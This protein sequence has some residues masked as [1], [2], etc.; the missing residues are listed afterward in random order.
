MKIFPKE[1][2]PAPLKGAGRA[3]KRCDV[4]R[5]GDVQGV[6]AHVAKYTSGEH[7]VTDPQMGAAPVAPPPLWGL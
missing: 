7:V 1:G 5:S 3:S 2:A 4:A 6:E